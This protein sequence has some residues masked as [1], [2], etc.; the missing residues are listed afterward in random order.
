M[1]HKVVLEGSECGAILGFAVAVTD[2]NNL[3]N[4]AIILQQGV[5]RFRVITVCDL[6]RPPRS[7]EVLQDTSV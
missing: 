3:A 6:D 5:Y 2:S 1:P 4:S 7:M